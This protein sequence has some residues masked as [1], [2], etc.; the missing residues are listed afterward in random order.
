MVDDD[1]LPSPQEIL[2]THDEIEQAYDMKYRGVRAPLPRRK[3]QRAIDGSD[4]YDDVYV[5]RRIS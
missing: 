2:D 1:R 4:Q 5:G 3:L